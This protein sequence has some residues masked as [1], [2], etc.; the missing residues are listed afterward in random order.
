VGPA[1]QPSPVLFSSTSHPYRAAHHA[2]AGAIGRARRPH[3]HW[4]A[5]ERPRAPHDLTPLPCCSAGTCG[6]LPHRLTKPRRHR[7]RRSLKLHLPRPSNPS[8]RAINPQGAAPSPLSQATAAKPFFPC[9][10]RLGSLLCVAAPL[11]VAL[12]H[13]VER[14]LHGGAGV[15]A[16]RGGRAEATAAPESLRTAAPRPG[17]LG[18]SAR[19]ST[20]TVR[21][22]RTHTG[23]PT[24][25][26][27]ASSPP[28]ITMPSP[29]HRARGGGAPRR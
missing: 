26:W 23:A 9:A 2:R 17:A 13:T 14:L 24:S 7:V 22:P 12:C 25:C 18:S 4:R 29:R 27:T 10:S 28:K 6:W 3:P 20:D 11:L 16:P 21:Q 5:L 8:L 1:R 19:S 15:V